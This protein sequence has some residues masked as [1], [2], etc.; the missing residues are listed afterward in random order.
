MTITA[1][2]W[3]RRIS[4]PLLGLILLGG[5]TLRVW[6]LNF[7]RA[8]RQP[9]RRTQHRLFLCAHDRFACQLGRI[10]D[11]DSSPMNPL[12]DRQRQEPR[13]F[14]Y[15]HFPLY[16]GVAMGQL[17]ERLAPVAQMAGVPQP[18]VELMRRGGDSCDAI[19]V[20]GRLSIALLDTL[21]IFL[22]FLLG[23]DLFG[24]SS[25]AAGCC[26]LCFC[27]AGNSAEPFFC[28]GSCQHDL[29]GPGCVG[30]TRMLQRER[31]VCCVGDGCCLWAG[32]CL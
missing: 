8:D 14:T 4:F 6:N 19:A 1:D 29:Y 27:R 32:C 13:S 21:T 17:F 12:W 10:L 20:A 2:S 28:D 24:Q 30:G 31:S 23:K 5:L 15:G 16:V 26:I 7:D 22:L 3:L 9:P 25:R 11:P 18:T